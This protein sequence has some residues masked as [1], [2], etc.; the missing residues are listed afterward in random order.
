MCLLTLAAAAV[1]FTLVSNSD[2]FW[3]LASGKWM[4]EHRRLLD[5]DPFSVDPQPEWVNIHWLFQVIIAGLH[6][7][8]GF[9]ML[10]ILKAGLSASVMLALATHMRKRISPGWLMFSGLAMLVLVLG[11]LR[12]RPE[13][14]S[15][16]FM[17]LTIAVL[18]SVRM[19]AGKARLWALVPVMLAWVNMHGLYVMGLGM[20]WSSVACDWIDSR[21]GRRAAS[22]GLLCKE[23]M[24]PL[25]S[26]TVAVLVTPW[27]VKAAL[28]PILL[29]TRISG[30]AIYYTYGVSELLPTWRA[31]GQH[32]DAVAIVAVAVLAI[33]LNR[34]GAPLA[35]WAWLAATAALAAMARRNIGLLGPVVGY[36]I[37]RHGGE[38]MERLKKARPGLTRLALPVRAAMCLL[39]AAICAGA[40]TS[41]LWRLMGWSQRFGAGLQAERHPI[42]AARFLGDFPGKGALFCEDFGD[43]STFIYY[44]CPRRK[45]YMDGRL[46]AHSQER[47]VEQHRIATELRTAGSADKVDLPDQVRFIFVG[48]D[49]AE[50]LSSLSKSRRFELVYLDIAGACF[51]LKDWYSDLSP[52]PQPNFA[53]REFVLDKGAALPPARSIWRMNPP[54][55][56]YQAGAMM[57][58]LGL[59]DQLDKD[60]P[61]DVQRRCILLAV[62]Y[63]EKAGMLGEV[64]RD[65]L[66]GTLA[67]A[68]QQ[69]AIQFDLGSCPAFPLDVNSARA[70]YLYRQLDLT[71]LDDFDVLMFAQQHIVALKQA[72]QLDAAVEAA[73]R[74]LADLPGRERVNPRR[75]YIQL[76]DTL[77]ESLEF[78]QVQAAGVDASAPLQQQAEMLAGRSIGLVGKATKTAQAGA[79][80]DPAVSMLLGDLLLRQG[81]VEDAR[82]AYREASRLG[83]DA[84]AAALREALCLWVEGD[85][86]AA[87]SSL[88]SP[89]DRSENPVAAYYRADLSA[90][91]GRYD[92][93]RAALA[94]AVS[95]DPATKQM[96]GL[97]ADSLPATTGQAN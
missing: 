47:F 57:L 55:L 96:L 69:R 26:A 34:R 78:S 25:L 63:L 24:A 32:L 52:L 17:M 72:R 38:V 59:H 94:K 92:E 83:A 58:S 22:G 73:E 42:A 74:F 29:W 64:R 21:L 62:R 30:Q 97:L 84:G 86:D 12:V 46:E 27:P 71:R 14:F 1:G 31:I 45:V 7:L 60:P 95:S 49:R 10:S 80:G 23:A 61:T 50:P 20:I 53:D 51:A 33:L 16:V 37:A 19:G 89:A 39:L 43:A 75:E 82:K 18:E 2:L 40:A 76:R 8:G 93:A 91:L 68:C 56:N 67:Q 28:H 87:R 36:I 88:Q 13:A 54:A 65:V 4:L 85:L 48:C 66:V 35:H 44:S 9:G 3:H 77:R 79:S 11:R 41:G 5:F 70:L 6:S 81:M 15:L 90:Q